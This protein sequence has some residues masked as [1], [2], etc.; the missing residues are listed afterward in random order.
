[1]QKRACTVVKQ[2]R[3]ARRRKDVCSILSSFALRILTR[4]QSGL[5]KRRCVVTG[6]RGSHEPRGSN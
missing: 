3:P 1:M 4:P 5:L 2:G 6:K